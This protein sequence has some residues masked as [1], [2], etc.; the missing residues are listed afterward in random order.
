MG[1]CG[2]QR[3]DTDVSEIVDRDATPQVH[4]IAERG[5]NLT[6]LPFGLGEPSIQATRYEV[7]QRYLG[8]HRDYFNPNEHAVHLGF[9]DQ[10][11]DGRHLD[12]GAHG[13][14]FR[15]MLAA[16]ECGAR[17]MLATVFWYLETVEEGGETYFPRALNE[18]GAEYQPWNG[19]LEDCYRGLAVQPTRGD[20]LLFYSM[21]PDGRL[22]ERSLHGGCA[23]RGGPHAQKWGANQWIW[24]HR[25]RQRRR[26]RGR[27]ECVLLDAASK[28]VGGAT[29]QRLHPPPPPPPQL[30]Q[31]QRHAEPEGSWAV[32]P[33]TAAV[34]DHYGAP[35][36]LRTRDHT[37]HL[38]QPAPE[39]A[40]EADI[41]AEHTSM[42][43]PPRHRHSLCRVPGA[44]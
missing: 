35:Q 27:E 23:P 43:P 10:E 39:E 28:A 1:G 40:K 34:V 38:N 13:E 17:N 11:P 36:Q 41:G 9:S 37:E 19:D 31:L 4:A 2:S 16:V 24:S 18:E 6:R 20:A 32:S 42:I 15:G 30:S 21:L 44:C 26:Q 12:R 29:T 3:A 25:P 14:L 22:D 33:I 8:A 5:H 7:G